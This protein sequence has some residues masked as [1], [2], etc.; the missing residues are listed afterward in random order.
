MALINSAMSCSAGV[1]SS[2]DDFDNVIDHYLRYSPDTLTL[3]D[4]LH[5]QDPEFAM[6]HVFKGYQ[7]KMASDPR[8]LPA[9]DQS[10]AAARASAVHPREQAHVAVLDA[11]RRDN[12]RQ[13]SDALASILA[14]HPTDLIALKAANH[15]H[16]YRGD[17]EGMRTEIL[18]SL[19]HWPKDHPWRNFV[20]GM[21][22]F[23][24]E[25][26][27]DYKAAQHYGEA[28]V[29]A[30]PLDMWAAH[31]VAHVHQMQ[32]TYAEGITWIEQ[33]G[34]Q[35]THTNNFGHHLTW[36]KALML[37]ARG[38]TEAALEVY[39][40]ELLDCLQDDFY[41]DICNAASLLWRLDL[42]GI[43]LGE[44]WQVLL[45]YVHRCYDQEL[46]FISL[47]YLIVAAKN[48]DQRAIDQA[49]SNL[50][51]W[52]LRPI[53]QGEVCNTVG[54]AIATAIVDLTSGH[55]ARGLAVLAK[56]LPELHLIGG[57]HAQRELFF[58]VSQ[59]YQKEL[60]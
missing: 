5:Q 54:L 40:R 30:E 27:G 23:G 4:T 12:S 17:A 16:F 24:H 7:L 34:K 19:P 49:M 29:D 11:W 48:H 18:A 38:Q 57:S 47:H 22:S 13:A 51:A 28:A 59:H 60:L 2:L 3:L 50:K 14:D 37:L 26:C 36:H 41:L 33:C 52:S 44:R 25:E 58:D 6:G 10:I 20:L 53:E 39:D 35:W 1:S 32:G 46:V 43:A 42:A 55:Q 31:A 56:A 9:L 15:L 8:L 21:L 45:D